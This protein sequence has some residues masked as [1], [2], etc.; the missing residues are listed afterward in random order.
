VSLVRG[1]KLDGNLD[2]LVRSGGS[3]R[4]VGKKV[5]LAKLAEKEAERLGMLPAQEEVQAVADAFLRELGLADPDSTKAWLKHEGLTMDDLNRVMADFAAVLAVESHYRER[6]AEA[7][8][9]H[10]RVMAAR[11]RQ[12][13]RQHPPR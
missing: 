5:L 13:A 3:D 2:V 11:G 12:L 6:L 7:V 4:V 8:D 10:R 9:L 1:A